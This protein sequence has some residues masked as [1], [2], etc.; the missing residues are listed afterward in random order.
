MNSSDIIPHKAEPPRPPALQFD[1][2][3]FLTYLDGLDLTDDQ[4][5]AF[6]ETIWSITLQFIDLGFGIDAMTQACGAN[7]VSARQ[8]PTI[9]VEYTHSIEAPSGARRA[10]KPPPR[11]AGIPLD[12]GVVTP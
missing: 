7:A 2:Q 6:I 11:A 3:A 9:P 8:T 5:H 1:A 10:K 12:E 4:K